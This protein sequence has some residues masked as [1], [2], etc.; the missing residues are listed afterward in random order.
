MCKNQIDIFF[1]GLKIFLGLFTP[2]FRH[3]YDLNLKSGTFYKLKISWLKSLVLKLH[4]ESNDI[5]IYSSL[6]FLLNLI[7]QFKLWNAYLIK[8][9]IRN[10]SDIFLSWNYRVSH[11]ILDRQSVYYNF[12]DLSENLRRINYFEKL[13]KANKRIFLRKMLGFSSIKGLFWR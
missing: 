10:V 7:Y 9:E 12:R 11:I 8:L 4:F 5:S 3:F 6:I 1:C 13:N 2:K